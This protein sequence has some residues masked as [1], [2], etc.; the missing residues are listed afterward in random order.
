[1]AHVSYHNTVPVSG[2]DL[3]LAV[4]AAA[5][6]D[7]AVLL[8]FGAGGVWSPSQVHRYFTQCGHAWPLTSVRRAISNLTKAGH[9]VITGGTVV[10]PYGRRENTWS[11]V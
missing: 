8:L 11:K 4:K 9:L 3:L 5:A 1:M 7:D 10:G 6:Q 2:D